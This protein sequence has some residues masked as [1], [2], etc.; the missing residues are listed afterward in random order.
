VFEA[1][2]VQ[3]KDYWGF[4]A[5]VATFDSE[6]KARRFVDTIKRDYPKDEFRIVREVMK[7]DTGVVIVAIAGLALLP[8]ALFG[9][10]LLTGQRREQA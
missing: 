3:V 4:W 8:L 7:M 5:D 10:N 1:Y 2:H 6:D 9:L